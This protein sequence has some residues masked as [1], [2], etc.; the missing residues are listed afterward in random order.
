MKMTSH[1]CRASLLAL[2]TLTTAFAD[3]EGWTADF[4]AAK[5]Q[6]AAE[7][8]DLLL[9]F[10]GSDWCGW[11]IKLDKEV[12][13]QDAF[14]AGVKDKLVLVEVDFPKDKSKLSDATQAQNDKLKDEFKIK[15]YPTLFLCDASAKP[16]AQ[17]GYEPDGPEK[18]V[19]HL[20]ALME[21]RAKRDAAFSAADKAKKPL[22]KAKNLI[23]G[24]KTLDGEIVE[25]YYSDVVAKIGELDKDDSTGFVKEQKAAIAKKEEAAA[26]QKAEQEAAAPAMKALQEFMQS[27]VMPLMQAK[28]F[29][30]AYSEAQDYLKANPTLPEDIKI[31]LTLNIGLP[32][33]IEKADVEGANKFLDEV[34]AAHPN[35]PVA[36]QTAQIKQQIKATIEKAKAQPAA[37]KPE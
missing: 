19:T 35:H 5:K 14:K 32:R 7:K 37:P 8:K 18:Y 3:R 22:D 12:F 25:A 27:K 9:D 6:A 11:C 36:K 10:T 16:Y 20:N 17:I 34:V 15:G 13:Q 4:D 23:A 1:L 24:L 30:K 21:V 26:A 31:D 28:D 33:F 29:D 2:V